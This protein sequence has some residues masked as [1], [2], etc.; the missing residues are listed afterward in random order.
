LEILAQSG[1][2]YAYA[3]HGG[4]EIDKAA[5]DLQRCRQQMVRPL[6]CCVCVCPCVCWCGW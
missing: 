5:G 1:L 2:K 6:P 4:M 3:H